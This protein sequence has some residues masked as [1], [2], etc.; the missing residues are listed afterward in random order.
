MDA[1]LIVIG[2]LPGV[3][4][5]TLARDLSK[6]LELPVFSKDELEAAV[7]RT[8]LASNKQMKGVGY[9]LMDTIAQAHIDSCSSVI[10]DFIASENRITE[11]W[12]SLRSMPVKYIECICSDESK[13]QER[14]LSR[15]RGIEGWYELSWEDIVQIKSIYS[16]Y[17]SE[18]LILDTVEDIDKNIKLALKYI[19]S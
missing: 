6:C 2:G 7:S 11:C 9:E 16:P 10:F 19:V 1:Q 5:T 13:H 14:I 4:K 3:G 8:G 12:P 17:T 18:R 15:V